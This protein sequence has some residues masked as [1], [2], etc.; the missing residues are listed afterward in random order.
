[1]AE[2]RAPAAAATSALDDDV[3]AATRAH[4]SDRVMV[5][6]AVCARRLAHDGVSE[7]QLAA[8]VDMWWHLVAAELESGVIDDTG[9][10]V[11][12]GAAME[13]VDDGAALQKLQRSEVVR[14]LLDAGAVDADRAFETLVL[15]P[16]DRWDEGQP[17][18]AKPRDWY[19]W[20]FNRRLSVL[21]RPLIPLSWE[22]DP[23]V[24]LAPSLLADSLSYLAMAEIG[25]RPETL[26]DS[27]EMIAFVGRAVDG[28]GHEFARKVENRLV[29]LEWKAA[30]EVGLARFGGAASLGDVDVLC[31][32]PSSGVVYAI[33]CK[34]LRF[35][36]TLGEIGERLSTPVEDSA[37][38]RRKRLPPGLVV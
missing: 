23:A 4:S 29:E 19:P 6:R 15:C 27:R 30:R 21:R 10:Y 33:E 12:H 25:R 18:N 20:R 14:Q 5:A 26:F 9:E 11:V 31:W 24:I 36:S 7:E 3:A 16:R 32:R 34:S 37:K 28:N 1:M 8:D 38:G 35:D 22:D 13:V 17:E 2:N